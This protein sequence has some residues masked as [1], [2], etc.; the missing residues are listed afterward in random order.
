MLAT[1]MTTTMVY[2]TKTIIVLSK[3]T[4]INWILTVIE[5]VMYAIT[6]KTHQT[7]IKKIAIKMVL[8]MLAV[9]TAMETVRSCS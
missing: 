4:E 3:L 9:K 5:E 2:W 1:P 8:V 7:T 6:V